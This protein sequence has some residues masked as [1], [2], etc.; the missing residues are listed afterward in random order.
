VPSDTQPTPPQPQIA[1]V[2]RAG[3]WFLVILGL[4]VASLGLLFVGLLGRSFLRAWE[5]RSWPE[6]KCIILSSEIGER[7]HDEFS[8]TEFRQDLSYGYEWN[9]KAYTGTHLSLRDNPWS[10]KRVLAEQRVTDF[11]SGKMTTCR[12]NPV[13]PDIAVLKMDSLAPG[14]SIWFPGLFVV[15]GLGISIRAIRKR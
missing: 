5:M 9:G 1:P 13:S 11:P 7:R 14:Y 6:V 3:R 2:S 12:L 8:P 4:F 10:S 15:G